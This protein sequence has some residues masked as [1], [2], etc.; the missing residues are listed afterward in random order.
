MYLLETSSY[1]AL[2]FQV[3][4]NETFKEMVDLLQSTIENN[5]TR[6]CRNKN[7]IMKIY[8]VRKADKSIVKCI[9]GCC[10]RIY[11]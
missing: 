3:V 6:L 7:N 8:F 10:V 1:Y 2:V 4:V 5:T 9:C 11:L